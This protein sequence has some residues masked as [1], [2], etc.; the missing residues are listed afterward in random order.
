MKKLSKGILIGIIILGC[1]ATCSASPL[2]NLFSIFQR[3][4]VIN[5]Q[6]KD[7]KN[8]IQGSEVYLAKDPKGQKTLIGNVKKISFVEPKASNVE[9]SIDKEYKEK[10]YETT[11][12][13]LIPGLF[14]ENSKPYIIAIPSLDSSP[15]TP[16]KSG[17]SVKGFTFLEYTLAVAGEELTELM[18]SFRKQNEE[19]LNQFEQ[20]I[21]NF[22][23]DAFQKQMDD[24]IVKISNFSAEQ[25]ETFKKEVLP[26]LRKMFESMME[27]LE[28]QNNIEKSKELEKQLTKI[29]KS[30]NV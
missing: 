14:A 7:H 6:Y 30:V 23:T 8:L 19:I 22:D 1:S 21:K 9:I 4:L 29:E 28:E 3:D 12:F 26:S 20:Y 10:I 16:L 27:K 11:R 5:V 15:Q 18:D 25:K 13:V 24:F 17:A 2:S